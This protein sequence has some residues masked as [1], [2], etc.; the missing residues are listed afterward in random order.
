VWAAIPIG[1]YIRLLPGQEYAESLSRALP[2]RP[3]LVYI[4]EQANAESAKRLALEIGFYDE[5]LPE[6]IL[7]IVEMAEKLS[8]DT[9]LYSPASPPMNPNDNSMEL[10]RRFFG[11]VFIA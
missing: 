11:G 8:C 7:N 6:L 3:T 2:V 5:D 4:P 9:S 1:R 10:S